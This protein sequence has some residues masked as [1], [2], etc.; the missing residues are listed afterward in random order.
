MEYLSLN[1]HKFLFAFLLVL[2]YGAACGYF[3]QQDQVP[4][5]EL[6]L[7]QLDEHGVGVL[8][9]QEVAK[10]HWF[11]NYGYILG[12]VVVVTMVFLIF[13]GDL[14]CMTKSLA[15]LFVF[16]LATGCRRPFEPVKFEVVKSNEEAFLLPLTGDAKKQGQ[17]DNEEYLRSN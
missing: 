12:W 6:A 8:A 11:R 2:G 7:R 15:I 1:W 14:R 10:Q 3:L 16:C 5:T 17:S 13:I 4:K 9:S